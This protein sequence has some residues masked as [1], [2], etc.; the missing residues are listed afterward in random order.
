M[1]INVSLKDKVDQ[2]TDRLYQALKYVGWT[3][4]ECA[5][6]APLTL[7]IQQLKAE[8][9]AVILGHS[10]QTPDILFGISDVKGDSLELSRHAQKTEAKVIVFCGVRFMAE[11]AKILSP[12]KTVLLPS[13]DAGCSLDESITAEDVKALRR[14]HPNAAVVCYVNTSAAVKAECDVCCTSANA[15]KVVESVP[16][17][18]VIFLPDEYMAKNLQPLT[19]KKIIPWHGHCIVH[20][21][22]TTAQVDAVREAYPDVKILVH[23]ESP[24]AVVAAADLAGGTGDMIRYVKQSPSKTFMLVTECGLSERL[25][26]ELPD[27]QFVGT[28]TLCPHM[29]K[30][31]LAN[32]EQVLEHPRPDQIIDIPEDIRLRAARA[33]DRMLALSA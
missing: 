22:F 18:E 15:L 14:R 24:E 30:I 5:L 29:K 20:E 9:H 4:G 28:C 17:G 32:V 7:R 31:N 1:T 3:K 21:T 12:E 27:R 6:H 13:P 11:T 16:Q 8:R 25:K 33:V 2:E 19:K 23:T 10:Y 26:V